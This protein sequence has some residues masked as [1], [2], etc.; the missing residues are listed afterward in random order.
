MHELG[1][2]S[3][4]DDLFPD[5]LVIAASQDL[6]PCFIDFS[7]YLASNFVLL[8]LTLHKR[9]KFLHDVKFL[10]RNEPYLYQVFPMGLFVVVFL[11]LKC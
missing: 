1:E 2:K 3:E 8:E 9:K 6:L 5:D 4:I 7:N 11:R 10:F